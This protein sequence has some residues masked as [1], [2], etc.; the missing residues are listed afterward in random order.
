MVLFLQSY[1]DNPEKKKCKDYLSQTSPLADKVCRQN[2][3]KKK[4]IYRGLFIDENNV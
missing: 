1:G 3:D 2:A 4:R